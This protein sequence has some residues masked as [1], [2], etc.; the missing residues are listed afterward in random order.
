MIAVIQ[1]RIATRRWVMGAAVGSK[2]FDLLW[3][4][5]TAAKKRLLAVVAKRARA[6]MMRAMHKLGSS[7][8]ALRPRG[9]EG[10][11][12]LGVQSFAH[13]AGEREEL[14]HEFQPDER[15][16]DRHNPEARRHQA[17]QDGDEILQ[18]EDAQRMR[19]DLV[20]LVGGEFDEAGFD[21]TPVARQQPDEDDQSKRHAG[22][23]GDGFDQTSLA[24]Q[25]FQLGDDEAQTLLCL[26]SE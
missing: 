19:F 16:A 2:S 25:F 6:K 10:G 18:A 11:Q 17:A 7:W 22:G 24:M 13:R 21:P 12:K 9:A 26:L 20:G 8:S 1:I 5:A 3:P 23:D 15:G 14:Q 4:R